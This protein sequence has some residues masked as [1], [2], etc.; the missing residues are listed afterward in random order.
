MA[1]VSALCLLG[2]AAVIILATVLIWPAAVAA[3]ALVVA[4]VLIIASITAGLT[5]YGAIRM[6]M[7]AI[8]GWF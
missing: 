2:L 1:A 6:L 3:G 8:T 4:I 5:L 7:R